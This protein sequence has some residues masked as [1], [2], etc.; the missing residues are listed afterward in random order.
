MELLAS[1]SLEQA[2]GFSGKLVIPNEDSRRPDKVYLNVEYSE[3]DGTV[4][5]FF[6]KVS[7]IGGSLVRCVSF[8]AGCAGV[9]VP[10]E[11]RGRSFVYTDL[12]TVIGDVD[13]S[14]SEGVVSLVRLGGDFPSDRYRANLRTLVEVCGKLPS[15]RFMGG[16]LL[17]VEGLRVGRFNE[18][19]DRMAPVFKDI[20]DTFVE[21][22]L[23]DLDGL[24]E[25]VRK[26]RKRAEST[27]GYA[28]K[29]SPRV[30]KKAGKPAK[31]RETLL[32]LF[33]SDEEVE[34]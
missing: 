6:R 4:N 28:A 33:S 23:D 12:D 19:K 11:W 29:K 2:R 21:V 32:S 5:E 9:V 7:G 22:R 3:K 20:Y 30:R 24:T 31:Q 13:Y 14:E 18:G 34:F 26:T 25:I 16:N 8:P 17:G 15:V 1:C 27:D 10:E